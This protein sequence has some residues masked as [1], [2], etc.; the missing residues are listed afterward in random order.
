[1]KFNKFIIDKYR[2]IDH[3]T[4]ELNNS[5]I[6]LIGVNESGKTSI[7]HAILAFDIGQDRLNQGYHLEYLNR[8]D[9]IQRQICEITAHICF[10]DRDFDKL[11]KALRAKSDNPVFEIIDKQKKNKECFIIKRILS[12]VNRPYILEYP[13]IED[14]T[15][16]KRIIGHITNNQPYILYFDDFTDRVPSEVSF[17]ADYITTGQIKGKSFKEWQCIIEEI[18]N[19]PGSG[20]FNNDD[21][22]K[23][24]PLQ[25]F[26]KLKEKD[27]RDGV[28]YDITDILEKEII[29]EWKKMKKSGLNKLADDSDKLELLINYDD[30]AYMFE[31]KVRDK[32]KEDK[33]RIFNITQRSKGFQWFFN[34]MI[35]LKFNPRYKQSAKNS[36]YLLDEPGSYLHASAQMELLKELQKV[37]ETNTLIY[38]THSHYLLNP[39]VIKLGSIRIAEKN[40]GNISLINYGDY[41]S[42]NENGALSPVYQALQLNISNE[43]IGKII[44]LEGITDFYFLSLIQKYSNLISK[45]IRLIAGS[46]SGASTTLISLGLSFAESF[47]VVFDNDKGGAD[48]IKKYKDEFGSTI[49]NHFIF[50]SN[51]TNT[52]LEHL[53]SSKDATLL[54]TNTKSKTIKKSLGI[55]FYD[56]KDSHKK[57]INGISQETINNFK[58]VFD[59]INS[60]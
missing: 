26:M 50:Y 1:M 60:L 16:E 58:P 55:F 20:D 44:I 23:E 24:K 21:S 56:F 46:G 35:K 19:K 27:I 6:P 15:I 41:S 59:S 48:A 10:N 36:I 9:T 42:K 49:T 3:I 39:N 51:H 32:S 43:F 11:K 57:F 4:L 38:C 8:Y 25:A 33:K 34:Y 7:L 40:K 28:L 31:F 18:F 17:N 14:K 54:M 37:S 30:K 53:I 45:D 13:K 5:I 29:A 52:C 22:S 47:L 12:Q 2:A